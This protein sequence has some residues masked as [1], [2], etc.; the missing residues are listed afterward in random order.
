MCNSKKIFLNE[1][2][3]KRIY[4]CSSGN[5]GVR[6]LRLK[7][8]SIILFYYADLTMNSFFPFNPQKTMKNF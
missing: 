5:R 1:K 2:N 3:N 8:I 4:T 7:T 6:D